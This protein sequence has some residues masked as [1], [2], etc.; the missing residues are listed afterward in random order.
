MTAK[1]ADTINEIS[2]GRFV[3]GIGAGNTPDSDY[4]AGAKGLD[5]PNPASG[6]SEE[7]ASFILSIGELGFEEVR[8]DVYPKT[9]DA[10]KAMQ[11]VVDI[12]HGA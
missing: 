6:T 12:V 10:L 8:C 11:P 4:E 7:I 9:T 5:I 2:G 3:L 1:I